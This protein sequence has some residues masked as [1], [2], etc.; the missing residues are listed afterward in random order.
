MRISTAQYYRVNTEQMQARQNKVA[1]TQAKLGSGKQILHP[2]EDPNKADLMSRLESAKEKQRVYGKNLDAAET[3]LTAEETVLTSM[4]QIMQRITELGIQAGNDTLGD[5]DRDVIGAEVR[6]LRGELLN[7]SN[8][9]DLSG[10]YIFSGNKVDQPA[11]VESTSGVISYNGDYGRF[12]I[13]V[14][15][16]R[17]MSVNTIG[18]ELFTSA[19]F[20]TL[21]DLV[22]KLAA[23]DGDGVRSAIGG[24]HA[25]HDKLTVSYGTMAGRVSEIESQR[26]IIEDT[27]LRL[28]ELL[29]REDDL[30]YATAVT[31]L[32][33]ESL[34]LQALQASF[35]KL[36]QIS[37]FDYI[38]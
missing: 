17:K 32:T 11:F 16:V 24:L 31:E 35:A 34:A 25:I 20:A 9:R 26:A 33:Q 2:S 7:L 10:N 29:M 14:S 19:D 12:E 38:R 3:R 6:A 15:D 23:D 4:I 30:D 22:A 21:D 1:E 28:D 36:S 5:E 27:Q 18:P 13:N 37:L 8:T